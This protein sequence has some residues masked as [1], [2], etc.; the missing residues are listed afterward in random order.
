MSKTDIEI[1]DHLVVPAC[2]RTVLCDA[3]HGAE[4]SVQYITRCCHLWLY[5][6]FRKCSTGQ[7]AVTLS[8]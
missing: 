5:C 6:L 7:I 2:M 3:V 4:M 1:C 8:D